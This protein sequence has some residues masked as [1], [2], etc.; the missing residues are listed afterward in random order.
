MLILMWRQRYLERFKERSTELYPL[1]EEE[2]GT[3]IRQDQINLEIQTK[4]GQTLAS[5]GSLGY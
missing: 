1:S 3:G 2:R 4:R 5:C